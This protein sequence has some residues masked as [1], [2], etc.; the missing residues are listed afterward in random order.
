[1]SRSSKIT[2]IVLA[3]SSLFAILLA[4]P[5]SAVA[6][7]WTG[8]QLATLSGANFINVSGNVVTITS[9]SSPTYLNLG[10]GPQQLLG[11][12]GLW[13]VSPTGG[14]FSGV[15][16]LANGSTITGAGNAKTT[17]TA[18]SSPGGYGGSTG[19]SSTGN[20]ITLA[21]SS[22]LSTHGKSASP[23]DDGSFTFSGL[24]PK[25]G[26]FFGI[27]YLLSSGTDTTCT[28]TA[29]FFEPSSI[30]CPEPAA[31]T[32]FAVGD[33]LLAGLV[34]TRRRSTRA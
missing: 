19:F 8:E 6:V 13:I 11:V 23:F 17:W 21:S 7:K 10:S 4:S 16:S 31:W 22:T 14:N 32:V 1:M 12:S 3:A 34:I 5:A 33:I 20:W 15:T 26:Y 25:T 2:S 30:A 18:E 27:D 24:A 9:L 29:F 28:G